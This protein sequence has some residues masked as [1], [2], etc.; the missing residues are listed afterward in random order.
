MSGLK[1]LLDREAIREIVVRYANGIDKRDALAVASC[2]TSD[3]QLEHAGGLVGPGV[4]DV[5]RY[6][7]RVGSLTLTTHFVGN[8]TSVVEGDTAESE[9]YKIAY[10]VDSPQGTIRVRGLRYH[11]RWL[12]T[13]EGWRIRY[14]RHSV[15][16]MY[17]TV[18]LP[19]TLTV[20]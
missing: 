9:T 17:E 4:D 15:D 16:W 6:V 13:M 19:T 18:A 7:M 14:R 10:L 3:A 8:M 2:F 12:R 20:F 5:V 1:Q 11:D